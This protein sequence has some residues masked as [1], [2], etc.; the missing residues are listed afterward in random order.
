MRRIYRV[1]KE[2]MIKNEERLRQRIGSSSTANRR[3]LRE[4]SGGWKGGKCYK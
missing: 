1:R 2:E 3:C 4:A